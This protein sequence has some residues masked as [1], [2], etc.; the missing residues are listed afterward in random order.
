MN[1][2]NIARRRALILAN[3]YWWFRAENIQKDPRFAPL[4][5]TTID[6][7]Y[8]NGS[9]PRAMWKNYFEKAQDLLGPATR[10]YHQWIGVGVY[11]TTD[12]QGNS[13]FWAT[14]ILVGVCASVSLTASTPTF[15]PYMCCDLP[16]AYAQ[17]NL[18][19]GAA[20]FYAYDAHT[21]NVEPICCSSVELLGSE[22]VPPQNT[23]AS[24]Y[25]AKPVL[26]TSNPNDLWIGSLHKPFL[27]A[28]DSQNKPVSA[29]GTPWLRH[30]LPK[31]S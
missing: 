4:A 31:I 16:D 14:I 13:H 24:G 11:C 21:R 1:D 26:V 30:L 18:P 6:E 29:W 5:I 8:A 20:F 2:K 25:Q 17:C 10:L 3:G 28:L 23:S 15:T 27:L 7:I 12:S 9:T 22:E 19:R